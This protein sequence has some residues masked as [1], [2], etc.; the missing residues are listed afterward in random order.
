M[1][2]LKSDHIG[3]EIWEFR[4]AKAENTQNRS[5]WICDRV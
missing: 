2:K 3:I 4:A 1:G 5:Y